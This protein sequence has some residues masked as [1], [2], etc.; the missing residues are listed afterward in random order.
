[1]DKGSRIG[2]LDGLRGC[3]ALWVLFGHAC[4][5][6]GAKIPLLGQPELG[7]DLF[8]V[9]SGFLMAYQFM[10]RRDREPWEQPKSWIKFWTRR[11]FR[12][13]PLY[14]ILLLLALA[15]G[16][17]LY[18]SR[19]IIDASRGVPGQLESR[20]LDFSIQNVMMHMTFAFGL[21]PA[22]AFRSPLPDWSIGLEMQFYAVFPFLMLLI[23]KRG[24]VQGMAVIATAAL[25]IAYWFKAMGITYPMASFLPL[26]LNVFLAG[27]MVAYLA[28]AQ[29]RRTAAIYV[30]MAVVL[31]A[32]PAWDMSLKTSAVRIV[33]VG[34]FI[35]LTYGPSI[36]STIAKTFR[37]PIHVLSSRFAN[38]LGEL[39]FGAYLIHLLIMQPLGAAMLATPIAGWPAVARFLVLAFFTIIPTYIL[40]YLGYRFVEVPWQGVGRSAIKSMGRWRGK[41]L[42]A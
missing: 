9:L 29:N 20:Y 31:M 33:L 4:Q 38:I 28:Q 41:L 37:R 13:A 23:A 32:L 3:A 14:F 8:I 1:M 36:S 16:G 26:K 40:A 7:V 15:L 35:C 2:S 42:S 24:P 17:Y 19:V 6:M 10:L 5:L 30:A 11:I 34:L 25:F 12:I 39:S 18:E 22:Y 27:M 21:V